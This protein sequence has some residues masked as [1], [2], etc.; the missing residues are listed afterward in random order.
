[1]ARSRAALDEALAEDGMDQLV[2]RVTNSRGEAPNLRRHV[3]DMIEEYARH[4]GPR[5]LIRESVDGLVGEDP[6][7]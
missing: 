1:M 6:P 4:A 2:T 3:Q 5:R 7:R